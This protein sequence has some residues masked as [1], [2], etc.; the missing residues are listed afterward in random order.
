VATSAAF[1]ADTTAGS[2]TVTAAVSGVS[3][4]ASFS[5]TNN[6]G[7]AATITATGGTPQ[8]ATVSTAFL[9]ALGATVK[10]SYGNPVSGASVTF[11]VVA[12]ASGASGSFATTGTTDVETTNASGVAATSQVLTAN[13]TAGGFTVTATSGAATPANF[14]LTNT[15]A[16]TIAITATGGATQSAQV[17]QAFA[18]PLQATV[19]S[20]GSPVGS[21]VSVT[22]T[23][24]AGTSGAS[25]TFASTGATD[26]ETTDP[27]GVATTSQ[28]LTANGT[29]G[30]FTVTASTPGAA[31]PAS[32]SLT[33]TAVPTYAFYLS[34]L[35]VTDADTADGPYFY[36]LAGAV[37]IDVNGNVLGGEQ[38]YNDGWALTSPEPSGDSIT[39]GTLT[40]DGVTGQ[41]T[42]TLITNNENVGVGG[43]ETLGVQ[44]VNSNH[45]L[46]TQF[47]GTATSSGSLDLQTT[48]NAS[49]NFA[50][51]LS[52]VDNVNLCY[53]SVVYGGVFSTSKGAVSGVYDVDDSGA[54]LSTPTLGT[55]FTGTTGGPTDSYGRGYVTGTGIA[56]TLVYYIVGPEAMRLIDVDTTDSAVGSAFGQG[57]TTFTNASLGSSVFG[58]E[59]NSYGYPYA[60]AGS[61]TTDGNGN[62]AGIGDEDEGG[63]VCLNSV[64]VAPPCTIGGTYSISNA[65]GGTT[66]NGYSYLSLTTPLQDFANLG[67]YMTDP[68]LNLN[69]P[70][71]TSSGLGGALVAD[72]D[73]YFLNGAGVLI[74]QTD[75]TPGHFTGSAGTYAFGAQDSNYLDLTGLQT[76]SEFDFVGEGS[77]TTGAFA[78]TGLLNDVFDALGTALPDTGVTFSGTPLPDATESTTGRYTLFSPNPT[79]NP[80]VVTIPTATP[81]AVDFNVVIYQAS[82]TQLFWLDEDEFSLWLGPIEQQGSLT[83][84]PA[85]KR[86]AAKSAKPKQKQ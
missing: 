13:A 73:G 17:N 51:T 44:F 43:T 60:A 57:T 9:T 20:G 1:T 32:F 64:T 14:S 79:P 46:I 35:E 31:T 50:F 84:V 12:G 37:T 52:G 36:A 83:G 29:A 67:I 25:G 30:G 74:P 5:L 11:T 75:T 2:Y 58:V 61:F 7:A 3:T 80:L 68:N 41:Y 71:N 23:V 34:G 8:S 86:G 53:C 33:N 21:G 19:T 65:A 26:T 76:G 24:V 48:T 72:M 77:F 59:S 78:G 16:T 54:P 63:S 69:D 38:D 4:P 27:S 62:L 70:N 39:G 28:V 81:I 66:Y 22:F 49:G 82:G 45:A 42:L 40:A 47:D 6:A 18:T 55:A 56:T 85:I 15:A 10:D